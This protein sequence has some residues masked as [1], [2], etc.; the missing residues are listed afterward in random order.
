[1]Y[2]F[3]T[4]NV[5]PLAGI[6]NMPMFPYPIKACRDKN[7]SYFKF[8]KKK[9]PKQK[10]KQTNR[11]PPF[12]LRKKKPKKNQKKNQIKPQKTKIVTS[13]LNFQPFFP[14]FFF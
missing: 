5:E 1:M 14:L 2:D 3:S 8:K 4:V 13:K 10:S 7:L 11:S 9:K 12:P 6:R